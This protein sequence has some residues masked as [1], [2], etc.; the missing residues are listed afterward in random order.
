MPRTIMSLG[1]FFILCIASTI[2]FAQQQ[3]D[4]LLTNYTYSDENPFVGT[5]SG[6]NNSGEFKVRGKNA[7]YF[8]LDE[9]GLSVRTSKIPVGVKWLDI[10]VQRKDKFGRS[11]R[12]F[13]IVKDE[14]LKN[15]V[16]AHRGA[17]KNTGAAENSLSALKHAIDMGCA[18]SEFD[19]HM[20]SDSVPVV[21]HDPTIQ[22]INI[23]NTKAS[24]LIKLKLSSG[25]NMPLLKSFIEQGMLQNR[26]KLILE[27]K[28]TT[29]RQRV[30]ELT[31]KVVEMV[32]EMKAQAWVDYI[33]FDFNSCLAI[34]EIDPYA[35]VAYLNGDKSPAELADAKLW[36]L[37]YHFGVFQ[38][39]PS[40]ISQAKE[41]GL[42]I[43]T[44]TVN[45]AELMQ[46]FLDRKV[47]FITTNE[48]EI[49]LKMVNK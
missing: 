28:P 35:R 22:G 19:I 23:A 16:I 29:S 36:G 4:I 30:Q 18:G 20:S 14:F 48:P 15:G 47:D 45:D 38:K 3:S 10:T 5:I 12:E 7:R 13:R 31:K 41:Y 46:W 8:N 21:N 2:I 40:W 1:V 34:K 24:E 43:N 42:T 39:N 27:I 17:F 11:R 6:K 32:H 44:W 25:E 33:S 37:D 49:L 26:T 9:K